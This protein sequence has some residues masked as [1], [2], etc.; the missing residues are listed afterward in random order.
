MKD[1]DFYKAACYGELTPVAEGFFSLTMD[2]RLLE[3]M[4]FCLIT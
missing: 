2:A 3:S 4:E 1:P